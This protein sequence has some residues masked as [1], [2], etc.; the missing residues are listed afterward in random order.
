[1]MLLNQYISAFSVKTESFE[2]LALKAAIKA[3]TKT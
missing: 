1:M 2:K 3:I